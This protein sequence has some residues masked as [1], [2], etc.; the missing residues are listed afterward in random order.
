M[1]EDTICA[2]STPAGVGGIAVVRISGPDAVAVADRLWHGKPLAD[3]KS[4]TIHLGPI[5]DPGS[6]DKLDLAVATLYRAPRSFTGE[7]VVEF[8][9]HG[10][11]WIQGELLKILCRNGARLATAG[12]FTRRAF[13]NGRLDL[14][15]AEAVAD[16]I[17]AESRNAQRVAFEQISGAYSAN[18]RSLRDEMLEIASLLE[19][20][21]DFSEEDVEFISREDLRKKVKR[22]LRTIDS[23]TSSFD[24]GRAIREG[25]PVVIIGQTNAGKSSLLNRLLGEEKAIVSDISGTTRDIIEDTLDID[26]LTFR[27]IDTAGL[28][29]TSD[30][31]EQIGIDRALDRAGR[32]RIILW[33]VDP[34]DEPHTLAETIGRFADRINSGARLLIALNK[35]DLTGGHTPEE[36]LAVLPADAVRIVLSAKTG[37]GTD[38]L[39]EVLVEHSG[40]SLTEENLSMTVTNLRHYEALRHS[41]EALRRFSDGLAVG[42]PGDLIA[43][44]LRESI[45]HLG[46]VTG[47]I[48][49]P[50]ILQTIFSRFCIGK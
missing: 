34:T 2:V 8:S 48:T 18:M 12:E 4:H 27:L 1:N 25:I 47:Q 38:R 9:V 45:H 7:D 43:Q 39:R 46:E 26:G 13:R 49:T 14:A 10:S 17:A 41:G 35:S 24:S 11:R 6:G 3:A 37:E 20:E 23:L 42:I 5:V 15:E 33:V 32:A 28:R 19:L 50:E 21:L 22:A 40:V 16:I 36:I 30:P 29:E 44:D 31:V